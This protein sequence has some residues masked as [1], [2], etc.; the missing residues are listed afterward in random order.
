[1]QNSN[2]GD[3]VAMVQYRTSLELKLLSAIKSRFVRL[4]L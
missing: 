3:I 4:R 1:M 2:L